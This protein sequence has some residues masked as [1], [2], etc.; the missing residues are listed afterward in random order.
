[1][2][3]LI[4][5][6]GTG[7]GG[8]KEGVES[9]AHAIAKS[10]RSH[11]PDLVV[12]VVTKQSEEST[13]PEIIKQCP[14]MPEYELIRLEDMSDIR[15]AYE[16]VSRKISELREKHY[17]VAVDFTSGTKAMSAGAAIAGA[18]HLCMLTYVG[19]KRGDN[20]LVLR[21][22]EDVK[23]LEF[24]GVYVDAEMRLIRRLFNCHQYSSCI[25]TAEN[26]RRLTADPSVGEELDRYQRLAEGYSAWDLFDHER[27]Y[28][29]LK[30]EGEWVPPG[31]KEFLG[32]LRRADEHE[33]MD[34]L[35]ADLLN[36]A[37]RRIKEGKYDDAVARLYRTVELTGQTVLLREYGMKTSEVAIE[38]LR[39]LLDGVQLARYERMAD[40]E[41]KLQLPLQ[42]TFELLRDLGHPLGGMMDTELRDNL[43][44]RNYSILA[45]GLDP[46]GEERALILM[47]KARELARTVVGPSRL[48]ELMEKSRFPQIVECP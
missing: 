34:F 44:K 14:N 6:V 20:N 37:E 26:L 28:G 25:A 30:G 43:N 2:K 10:I 5:T 38:R 31:N 45:H 12:F 46:V 33:R 40:E 19:G 22:E 29:I 1:M 21:G 32:R 27:A 17:E 3:A 42:K 15:A 9:L 11:N 41:G 13:V 16:L 36:N 39:R 18:G 35:I 4:A 8:G 48:D 7:I 23:T 47:N 24:T